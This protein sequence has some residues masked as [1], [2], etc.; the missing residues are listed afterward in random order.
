MGPGLTI[1]GKAVAAQHI[2]ELTVPAEQARQAIRN[3]GFDEV[4]VH[5][6]TDKKDYL[7]ASTKLE[8]GPLRSNKPVSLTIN[9]HQATLIDYDNEQTS[10]AEGAMTGVRNG[11]RDLSDTT[12]GAV[13]TAVGTLGAGGTIAM[14]GASVG[15]AGYY[16]VRSGSINAAKIGAKGFMQAT[17]K[18]LLQGGLTTMKV[19]G[20][21]AVAGAGI[22]TIAGA[23]RGANEANSTSRAQNFATLSRISITPGSTQRP[24]PADPTVVAPTTNG[25]DTNNVVKPEGLHRI[26]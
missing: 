17:S 8:L 22:I 10:L 20:I 6:E 12:I 9:G 24:T 11:W 3:N 13:R 23:I 14:V 15:G 4:L 18:G 25:A 5:D 21:A 26:R 1:N 2:R 19:I 16:F 7:V